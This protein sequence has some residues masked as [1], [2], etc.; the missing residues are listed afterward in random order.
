M[1]FVIVEGSTDRGGEPLIGSSAR[2]PACPRTCLFGLS[3]HSEHPMNFINM[4]ISVLLVSDVICWWRLHALAGDLPRPGRWRGFLVLFYLLQLGGLL[5]LIVSR[6]SGVTLDFLLVKPVL[7]AIY[8]WHCLIVLPLALLCLI[9]WGVGHIVR[10]VK[11]FGRESQRRDIKPPTDRGAISRRE[12]ISGTVVAAPAIVCLGAAAFSLPQL[13]HFRVRR[14]SLS[15]DRLPPELNGLTIAHVSDLHVGRFTNGAVLDRIVEATNS[16]GADL[17]LL[18]GDL[19]NYALSDLPAALD[20]VGQMRA[21]HGVYLCE[22]NHDLIEDGHEFVQRTK[23]SGLPLLVNETALVTIRGARLQLLGL[24]W[25]SGAVASSRAVQH[26]DAA[27]EASMAELMTLRDPGAFPILLAHHPH[28]FDYAPALPLTLAG[29]THGGQLMVT[30]RVGFGPAMFRYWSGLYE[31]GNR[32][33]IVSNG[34][35]NWFPLRTRA[36]AEIIHLT[37]TVRREMLSTPHGD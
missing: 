27:I 17:V 33:L 4:V 24:R 8:L 35:G 28:A 20:L 30:D 7:G 36:P 31:S 13:E 2:D 18:T 21:G 11:R 23:A 32:A 6:S 34:V 19:I 26:G 22:G 12:F 15:L 5:V 37:L 10:W 14:Y 16:L 9:D 1:G 25:G 3:P 29:H